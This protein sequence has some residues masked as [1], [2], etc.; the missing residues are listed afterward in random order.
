[1][2]DAASEKPQAK[3]L[4]AK[5]YR[6]QDPQRLDHLGGYWNPQILEFDIPANGLVDD[7]V[8]YEQM[9]PVDYVCGAALLMHRSVP[10]A[11]GLLEPRFF[12]FWEESDF[13]FRAVR[14]GFEVW[15]APQAKVWH[16]VSSSFTGGKPHSHYFWWRSRLLWL[17]RNF[18]FS[19][20]RE[21]YRKVIIPEL[22]KE[23]RHFV[24]RS[25]QNGLKRITFRKP[26]AK[27]L[28]KTARLRAGL[29]GAFHYAINRFGNCPRFIGR[30]KIV[31]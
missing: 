3:I 25:L 1:M 21:M 14:A 7:G 18:S 29:F 19:E 17:E 24:L 9:E 6:Y 10:E 30:K 20:R 15:T 5:I 22:W 31:L 27:H 16:K 8:S 13:C 11:I 26:D 23:A 28:Q 4:G 2:M 12:L